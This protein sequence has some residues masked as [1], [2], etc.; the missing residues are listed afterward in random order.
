MFENLDEMHMFFKKIT[1]KMNIKI[2]ENMNNLISIRKLNF[3]LKTFSQCKPHGWLYGFIGELIRTFK[4]GY[5]PQKN[6]TRKQKDRNMVLITKPGKDTIRKYSDSP[7][8]FMKINT[9]S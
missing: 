6:S 8:L 5:Q 3:S 2:I 4:E 7:I 1:N 9:K